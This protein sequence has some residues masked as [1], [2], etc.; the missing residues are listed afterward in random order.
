MLSSI[1]STTF[2]LSTRAL[3]SRIPQSF[4]RLVLVAIIGFRAPL[5]QATEPSFDALSHLLHTYA[6]PVDEKAAE[7]APEEEAPPE[8]GARLAAIQADL[9]LIAEGFEAFRHPSHA[10]HA[11]KDLPS[12]IAPEL[13]PYFKDRD[14]TLETV[15]RTLAVTDYTWALRFP[16]PT[17]DPRNR[18]RNLLA[19]KDG[20][21]TDPQNGQLSPWLVRLLG[22]AAY[23]RT[24]EEALDRASSKQALSDRDY[25]LTRIKV[26][27][28]TEALRSDKAVGKERSKLYCL[29]AES[30]ETLASAH[31]TRQ[32]EPIQASRGS[33]TAD[34]SGREVASVLLIAIT[35]GPNRFRAVGA[36]V[37]VETPKGPKV[38]SDARLAPQEGEDK[39]SF[40]AFTRAKDG[41]LGKPLALIVERVDPASGIMLGR[42]EGGET[43]SGLKI[44]QGPVSRNELF[45]A[46]GHLSASGAWTVSQGLV[47]ETGEGTF[48]SD[49]ILGPD[50]IGSPLL[51]DSGEVTG[52]VVLSPGEGAPVAVQAEHLRRIVDG[53]PAAPKDLEFLA[54]RQTGSAS[55]L[56][57]AAPMVGELGV[58][59]GAA[60]E[61]GLPNTLG[62]V[63]WSG[64]GGVGNWR[65]RGSAGRPSGYSSSGSSSYSSYGSGKSAGTEI[66]EALA[67]LVEALIFKGIPALFRGIGSLFKSKPSASAPSKQRDIAQEPK[68][69]VEKPKEPPKISGI[70]VSLDRSTALEGEKVTATARVI[71]TD[72][73]AKK[74]RISVA[75]SIDPTAKVVVTDGQK[76]FTRL[77]D[78]SGRATI[79]YEINA[80]AKA[81]ELPFDE[82]KQEERR[83]AGEEPISQVRPQRKAKN[84]YDR[85]KAKMA[86]R[87]KGLDDE[88]AKNED[89]TSAADQTAEASS[90][91]LTQATLLTGPA[92]AKMQTLYTLA[93]KARVDP[94]VRPVQ[95]GAKL[96]DEGKTEVQSG[97]CPT[98]LVAVMAA[99]EPP[100]GSPGS[101]AHIDPLKAKQ[102]LECKE[103]EDRILAK[104]ADD[105]ACE[106]RELKQERYFE[107][108]CESRWRKLGGVSPGSVGVPNIA[109]R[110]GDYWCLP[111]KP[112]ARK[113]AQIYSRA[114]GAGESKED[115]EASPAKTQELI[116]RILSILKPNGRWIGERV[117]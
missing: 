117:G 51:N 81:R 29:R 60:I 110:S 114:A 15:Y 4:V 26:A 65:P 104:C 50:M 10:Q 106:A 56:T 61:A 32:G 57:A 107:Q 74:D 88:E 46:V 73:S 102:L 9:S 6:G 42:L 92:A 45:L 22:P 52:L 35:E 87:F 86:D 5:V 48:A 18:R 96:D 76:G 80:T 67:P 43:Q 37:I 90:D 69:E 75:F 98:G 64:G 3:K 16:E 115:D 1:I 30:Y 99:P 41:S 109:R 91:S 36:G 97:A 93:L 19:A 13:R 101:P 47:T 63:N 24:A 95:P 116:D 40:R 53:N 108:G 77:T 39:T 55:V 2:S 85:V 79:T 23:G 44:A 17:C 59:G 11:L 33:V 62:G 7:S 54:A 70:E 89:E 25:E 14:S 72:D 113:G 100:G 71:F 8:S 94:G 103:I 84:D 38:L 58:P 111:A 20:L 105:L 34:L 78:A 28:I 27:K 31:Q 68:R 12:H 49:A 66:G 112:R 82:L 83:R 21:F